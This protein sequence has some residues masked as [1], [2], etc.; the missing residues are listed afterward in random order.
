[1]DAE[2]SHSVPHTSIDYVFLG[3]EDEKTLPIVLIR[4]HPHKIT[5]SHCVPCKG[6][7]GSPHPAPQE[8]HSIKQLGYAKVVLKG[9]YASNP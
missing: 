1:M 6:A 2:R 5:Y 4:D 7:V 9:D 3:Q 8:A